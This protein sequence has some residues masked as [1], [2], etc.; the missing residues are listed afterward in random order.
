M[1]PFAS[2]V[3][4]RVFKNAN[5]MTKTCVVVAIVVLKI[6][7]GFAFACDAGFEAITGGQANCHFKGVVGLNVVCLVQ[8]GK[9]PEWG[10]NLELFKEHRYSRELLVFEEDLGALVFSGACNNCCFG[11]GG[12]VYTSESCQRGPRGAQTLSPVAEVC[13][14]TRL[15]VLMCCYCRV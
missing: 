6:I 12:H 14:V 15:V 13:I 8:I 11:V 10:F 5:Q 1:V 3:V 2:K 7:T 9:V 4:K